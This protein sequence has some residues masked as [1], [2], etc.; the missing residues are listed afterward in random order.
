MNQAFW[1]GVYPGVSDAMI[2][3]VVETLAAVTRGAATSGASG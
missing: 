1:V 3:Y 2:D